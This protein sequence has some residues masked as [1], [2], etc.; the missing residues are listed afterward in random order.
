MTFIKGP[1]HV[2]VCEHVIVCAKLVQRETKQ[3]L[4]TTLIYYGCADIKIVIRVIQFTIPFQ[5]VAKILL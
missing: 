1:I 2:V 3:T 5:A 4:W